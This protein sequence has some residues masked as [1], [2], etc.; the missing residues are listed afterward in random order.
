M[1]LNSTRLNSSIRNFN[2]GLPKQPLQQN[3][4]VKHI[5]IANKMGDIMCPKRL[6]KY[7]GGDIISTKLGSNIGRHTRQDI[8]LSLLL[9]MTLLRK[10]YSSQRKGKRNDVFSIFYTS[11]WA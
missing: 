4:L 7:G 11:L 8:L 9:L 3:Y 1:A 5:G 6:F 10:I 2:I